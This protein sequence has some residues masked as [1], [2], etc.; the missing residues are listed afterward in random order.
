A[1]FGA[2][3]DR[4][5]ILDARVRIVVLRLRR[6]CGSRLRPTQARV[7]LRLLAGNLGRA[8]CPW[9]E[10]DA[11]TTPHRV[12]CWL[13]A[14][15]HPGD[16]AVPHPGGAS[17]AIE[18]RPLVDLSCSHA[19]RA[20]LEPAADLGADVLCPDLGLLPVDLDGQHAKP[21]CAPQRPAAPS[22]A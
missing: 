20:E 19:D 9:P 15:L 18:L 7:R 21:L 8:S 10:C 3:S 4:R 2:I 16:H 22:R 11:R 14:I 1:A 17:V 13:R 6:S 12:R 5:L